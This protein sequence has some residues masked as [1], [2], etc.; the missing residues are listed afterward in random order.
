MKFTTAVIFSNI[1][2]SVMLNF[3]FAMNYE[4]YVI[5]KFYH[6][7]FDRQNKKHCRNGLYIYKMRI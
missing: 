2:R 7:S 5:T 3:L 4:N 1:R 6:N